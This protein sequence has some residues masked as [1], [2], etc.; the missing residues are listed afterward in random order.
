MHD[1]PKHGHTMCD[2]TSLCGS[3][4]VYQLYLCL[5]VGVILPAL[6]VFHICVSVGIHVAQ[7]SCRTIG[8]DLVESVSLCLFPSL[9]HTHTQ[10]IYS[11]VYVQ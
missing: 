8:L 11:T 4:C 7:E 10:C 9:S 5:R 3:H 2:C 6:H 1:D